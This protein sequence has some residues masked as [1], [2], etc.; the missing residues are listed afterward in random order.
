MS[1][2]PACGPPVEDGE[3]GGMLFWRSSLTTTERLIHPLVL[4]ADK[5]AEQFRPSST[6]SEMPHHRRLARLVASLDGTDPVDLAS[7]ALH[8][9]LED[10]SLTA[11]ALADKLLADGAD[12]VAVA[13][14]IG[15]V[16]ELTRPYP[17]ASGLREGEKRLK[18]VEKLKRISD[19]AKR[20]KLADHLDT[21]INGES[22]TPNKLLA[23]LAESKTVVD[24]CGDVDPPLA[25]WLLIEI[26]KR[27]NP[28]RKED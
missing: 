15:L 2:F 5:I 24:I 28:G 25:G 10:S 1:R 3:F 21:L 4:L 9:L 8:E 13:K 27:R 26:G 19:R 12:P 18:D 23:Y 6:I 14:V 7:A 17:A 20:I 16:Q 22:M 11:P